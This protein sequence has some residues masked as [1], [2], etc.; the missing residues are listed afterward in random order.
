MT[1]YFNSI[2]LDKLI[3][4]PKF[5]EEFH[6]VDFKMTDFVHN[7]MYR[8]M[9]DAGLFDYNF[10]ERGTRTPK[11]GTNKPSKTNL[12]F[13]IWLMIAM[14][15]K[16]YGFV[17]KKLHKVKDFLFSENDIIENLPFN[18]DK[19]GILKEIEKFEV[20]DKSVKRRLIKTISSGEFITKNKDKKVS[21][22]FLSIFKLITTGNDIAL[23]IDAS[24]EAIFIDEKKISKK[25]MTDLSFNSKLI[26]PLKKYLL[27]F[28][29]EYASVEFLTRSKILT[30]NEVYILNELR[31]NDI[32]SLT[33]KFH[34]GKPNTFETKM[35]R[36]TNIT[37]RLSEVLLKGGF[38]DIILKTKQGSIYFSEFTHKTKL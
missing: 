38:E 23:Y 33:V 17:K 13:A 28:I 21:R 15:L 6:S 5:I 30:D 20:S 2:S 24:G 11:G 16:D 29:G 22:L 32:I 34:K 35:H 18:T 27:F 37:A 9:N 10:I 26:L 3:D 8:H 19:E 36:K 14:D 4:L 1:D 12:V 31:R 7:D 25:K